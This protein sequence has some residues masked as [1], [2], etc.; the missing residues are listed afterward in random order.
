MAGNATRGYRSTIVMLLFA[1]ILSACSTSAKSATARP[2][3]QTMSPAPGTP[4]TPTAVIPTPSP[5]PPRTTQATP[6][7]L[8]TL[9]AALGATRKVQLAR[10]TTKRTTTPFSEQSR[11]DLERSANG[12]VGSVEFNLQYPNTTPR[13]A[14]GQIAVPLANT[15]EFLRIL[16]SVQ[17]RPGERGLP[18]DQS[19]SLE[20]SSGTIEFFYETDNRDW[21]V[22]GEATNDGWSLMFEG[23]QYV[24]PNDAPWRAREVIKPY[25]RDDLFDQMLR[26]A[27]AEDQARFT[28]PPLLCNLKSTGGLPTPPRATFSQA[29]SVPTNSRPSVGDYV[30]IVERL[31]IAPPVSITIEDRTVSTERKITDPRQIGALIALLDQPLLVV[32]SPAFQS[33]ERIVLAIDTNSAAAISLSYLPLTERIFIFD[34]VGGFSVQAPPDLRPILVSLFCAP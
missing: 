23:R 1:L 34:P 8:P 31:G 10:S 6:S 21:F 4:D 29:S 24:I 33:N 16:S 18:R 30:N 26:G 2:I 11:W 32:P 19:I 13:S 20:T 3:P 12:L 7:T 22:P 5:T 25:L 27:I 9:A 28:P 17:V 15:E 14:T